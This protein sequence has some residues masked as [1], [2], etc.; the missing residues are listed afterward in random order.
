MSYQADYS[1]LDRQDI[2]Q[3]VFY[4]RSDFSEG[5]SNAVD[6]FIPVEEGVSISCRFYICNQ[7]SPIIV[8]FHGNGE[9]VSDYDYVAPA[10]NE[11][12]ISLFVAD[13]RGY[14]SSGGIPTFANTIAD[15][16]VIFEA[17]RKIL[18]REHYTGALFVMGRSLGS[19]PA[20]EL[21]HRYQEQ[22]NGLII[23]SGFGSI[24]RLFS[25][26][27][28]PVGSIG[29]EDIE[30]PNLVKMRTID[31]PV[32]IIHG[33]Y[34]SLVPLTEA[35][36]LFSSAATRDKRLIVIPEADHNDIMLSHMEQYFAVIK[37]FISA[38]GKLLI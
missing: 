2:L 12:G 32:L 4:P 3:F 34:D 15:A 19:I 36:D 9:V 1:A 37:E 30:F 6:Y 11:L 29:L 26:L 16:P 13:Y 5:P 31:L 35:R 10:Y 8:F 21:A 18:E 14:G 23:E 24:L 38:H 27:D 7:D 20:V 22:M 17:F 28:F 33:E 25:H